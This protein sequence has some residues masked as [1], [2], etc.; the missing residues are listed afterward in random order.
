VLVTA[1]EAA[2][3]EGQLGPVE[4]VWTTPYP[5]AAWAPS[6]HPEPGAP[7][8]RWGL[9]DRFPFRDQM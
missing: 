4:P 1:S 5:S 3:M 6:A 7:S 9:D 2:G 8:L